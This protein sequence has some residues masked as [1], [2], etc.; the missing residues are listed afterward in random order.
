MNILG[1]SWEMLYVRFAG[2]NVWNFCQ[3]RGILNKMIMI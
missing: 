3:D 1:T 2:E